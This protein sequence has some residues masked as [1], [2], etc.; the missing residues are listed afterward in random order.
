VRP[1]LR[2][3]R[4]LLVYYL[5]LG[6]SEFNW[7]AAATAASAAAATQRSPAAGASGEVG[8]QVKNQ[9]FPSFLILQDTSL[10][11]GLV[12]IPSPPGKSR[13]ISKFFSQKTG[14]LFRRLHRNSRRAPGATEP[15]LRNKN[16]RNLSFF[17]GVSEFKSWARCASWA[18]GDPGRWDW[19]LFWEFSGVFKEFRG[20]SIPQLRTG[21][22][23]PSRDLSTGYPQLSLY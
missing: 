19:E 18:A 6:V 5:S 4:T 22:P 2:E 13:C 23:A 1:E 21:R 14:I 16:G 11:P 15:C 3:P 17:T 9:A 7:R 10:C 12:Y 20:A 8:S